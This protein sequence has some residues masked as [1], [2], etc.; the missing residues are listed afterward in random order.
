M[1]KN[2]KSYFSVNLIFLILMV[3]SRL[4]PH[5]PNF[6]PTLVFSLLLREWCS[7][8]SALFWVLLSQIISD[9]L[10]AI[11]QH[12]PV[13]GDWSYFVYS[14][15]LMTVIFFQFRVSGIISATLLFWLWTNFGVFLF[16]GFY[17]PSL[18]GLMQCYLLALP[19]LG[20][21]VLGAVF[22]YAL[23]CELALDRGV[24]NRLFFTA[25]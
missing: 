14:G 23:V 15:L 13:W 8:G 2:H 3:F 22:Y 19:F 5:P 4:V 1:K 10:L 16:S 24:L 7:L 18:F 6:T 20:W 12:Y 25:L 9:G 17:F 11:F 21:S